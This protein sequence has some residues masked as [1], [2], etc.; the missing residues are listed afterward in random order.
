MANDSFEPKLGRLGSARSAEGQRFF[1]L[2]MFF[3]A[4]NQKG[5]KAGGAKAWARLLSCRPAVAELG[6]GKGPLYALR[7]PR[8][9][10]R[11]V[12]VKA[13]IARHGTTDLGA[14]RAHQHTS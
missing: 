13:R 7:P 14:A 3:Q 5:G 12:V 2:V 11:R 6:C 8:P 4:G 1:K 10:W 9:E